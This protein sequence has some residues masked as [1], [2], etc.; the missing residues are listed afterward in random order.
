MDSKKQNSLLL[1]NVPLD[2]LPIKVEIDIREFLAVIAWI[3]RG[4]LSLAR[5]ST[6]PTETAQAYQASCDALRTYFDNKLIEKYPPT[7]KA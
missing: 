7:Y 1:R 2:G 5:M 4:G 6:A 3:E